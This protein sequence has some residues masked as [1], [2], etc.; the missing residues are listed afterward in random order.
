MNHFPGQQGSARFRMPGSA[1][2]T[3]CR[4]RGTTPLK[5]RCT[6]TPRNRENARA[7]CTK[8]QP[9]RRPSFRKNPNAPDPAAKVRTSP[10]M[11]PL[12]ERAER[13]T[14]RYAWMKRPAR[15]AA[16][17]NRCLL[18]MNFMKPRYASANP[19][20][21]FG[22]CFTYSLPICLREN[23]EYAP[24]SMSI[25]SHP[26][27]VC[28]FIGTDLSFVSSRQYDSYQRI[29]LRASTCQEPKRSS[30]P[31]GDNALKM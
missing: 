15:A 6:I 2:K 30:M 23:V 12:T 29:D 24:R 4:Q 20:Y 19:A 8:S 18:T 7:R 14:A 28:R 13:E 17:K 5:K 1:G 21:S 22:S 25:V 31:A 3:P 11:S 16:P 10:A 9:E 27:S 26:A